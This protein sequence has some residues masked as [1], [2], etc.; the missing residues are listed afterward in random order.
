MMKSVDDIGLSYDETLAGFAALGQTDPVAGRVLGQQ[1]GANLQIR[2]HVI[3]DNLRRFIEQPAHAATLTGTV[4]FAPL[5]MDMP[6]QH[7]SHNV[8]ATDPRI[9]E[10]QMIYEASFTAP[11]GEL[12]FL[13]G[14]KHLVDDPGLDIV[15]D[16][17]TLF[18]LVY[19]GDSE[20]GPVYAAGQMYFDLVD[21][22]KLLTTMKVTG[23]SRFGQTVRAKLAYFSFA[24]GVLR[25]TYLVDINPVYDTSMQNVVIQGSATDE[26]GGLHSLFLVSGYHHKGFPWGDE[27]SFSDVLLVLRDSTGNLRRFAIASRRL[28][29]HE[30]DVQGGK[31][32]YDGP[33]FELANGNTIT[34]S[35]MHAEPPLLPQVHASISIQFQ[36]QVHP[37]TPVPFVINNELLNQLAYRARETLQRTFPSKQ[38]FGFS[39][40]PSLLSEL[41]G[42][43]DLYLSGETQK[44]TINTADSMGEGEDTT[45]RNLREPTLLY[46][47]ILAL[48]RTLGAARMQFHG[49]SLRNEQEHWGKDRIDALYSLLLS[50]FSTQEFDIQPSGLI[51]KDLQQPSDGSAAP[52]LFERL[53]EPLLQV[54]LDHFPTA[55]FQRKIISVKDPSGEECLALEEAME[56]LRCESIDCSREV[57]VAAIRHD[58]KFEALTRALNS[59]GFWET[60]E[61]RRALTNKSKEEFSIIIKPNFMFAY[62]R[63]DTTTYTDPALIHHLT[64]SLRNGGYTNLTVVEAQSTYGEYFA[65]RGVL[66]VAAYLGFAT[67]GREYRLVDLTTDAQEL[68]HLGVA[69]GYHPV[70]LTWRDA[71]FRIS[72]AKNKTHSYAFYTLTLKNIYGA[73]SLANKFKEYHCDRSIGETTIEYLSAFPVHFGI[74][75]AYCSADGP[76]G[77]FA[78]ASPNN[79][80][81]IIAG[82]DL[83][84]VDWVGASKMGIDPTLSVY[85]KLALKAFGKP[86]IKLVGDGSVYQPWLNVPMGLTLLTTFGLDANHY[87]GNLLYMSAAYMDEK[88]FPLK[89]RSTLLR[90]ARAALRPLQESIFLQSGGARSRAN[91]ALSKLLTWLGTQPQG[92]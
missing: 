91:R 51:V 35:E 14:V 36:A 67:D 83:V 20:H 40:A 2:V 60:L 61:A 55:I 34:F 89:S 29:V 66:D 76:F 52:A 56:T 77:I 38:I 15:Q 45:L 43:I 32:V 21:A 37:A 6:I 57:V 11:S 8:L 72:F 82:S 17:T 4:S 23:A 79:T 90:A 46:G 86:K 71:D 47:Y 53:G 39:I 22:P 1:Q 7:G 63:L 42:T 81:T 26:A 12:F 30:V 27:E 70:P 74:I 16:M 41:R 44:L 68:R 19:R 59:S 87:F 75:D 28:S 18:V 33:I 78:D 3:V 13:R 24:Y 10:R 92:L 54:D 9:G 85:M 73:L 50:H 5:G 31:L 48:R 49:G 65:N 25:D 69:L 80:K 58:D 64:T 84:A 88:Q 62:N